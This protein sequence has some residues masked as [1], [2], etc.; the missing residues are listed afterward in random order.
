MLEAYQSLERWADDHRTLRLCACSQ[1]FWS[2]GRNYVS[3]S[4]GTREKE[5]RLCS[6]KGRPAM[7]ALDRAR[8]IRQQT[9]V[10]LASGYELRCAAAETRIRAQEARA[11][12]QVLRTRAQEALAQVRGHLPEDKLPRVE[13]YSMGDCG[14]LLLPA[15]VLLWL[16][17]TIDT[18]VFCHEI[19]FTTAGHGGLRYALWEAA[20]AG[21]RGEPWGERVTRA[22][23]RA[24]RQYGEQFGGKLVE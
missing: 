7:Q 16:V 22:L 24:L 17:D 13:A 12:A 21:A 15:D 6:P 5:L 18:A 23:E 11:Q 4:G 10:H 9:G 8:H 19:G 20:R 1:A 3:N 2:S 14:L